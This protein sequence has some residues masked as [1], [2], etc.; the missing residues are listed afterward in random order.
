MSGKVMAG[1]A[2]VNVR[3]VLPGFTK[4]AIFWII[5]LG[6]GTGRVHSA[7]DV[8]WCSLIAGFYLLG[9]CEG[10]FAIMVA[11]AKSGQPGN[12]ELRT[13]LLTWRAHFRTSSSVL[14]PGTHSIDTTMYRNHKKSYTNTSLIIIARSSFGFV[15]RRLKHAV[16][17]VP[18]ASSNQ[19]TWS[20]SRGK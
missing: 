6:P 19:C 4:V 15:S 18:L 7:V 2:G 9:F 16:Y 8:V 3:E 13:R 1:C 14:V 12:Q 5:P 20:L 10:R 17:S 11:K